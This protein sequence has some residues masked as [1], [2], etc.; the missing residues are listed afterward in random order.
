MLLA[1]QAVRRGALRIVA[2]ADP[3]LLQRQRTS[4]SDMANIAT[5][6]ASI[7][8]QHVE[9]RVDGIL[10]PQLGDLR[11]GLALQRQQLGVLHRA[12]QDRFRARNLLPLVVPIGAGRFHLFADA[13]AHGRDLSAVR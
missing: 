3:G 10:L 8:N 9:D 4:G 13:R 12:H 6:V 1:Q 11:D 5:S 2:D 7:L